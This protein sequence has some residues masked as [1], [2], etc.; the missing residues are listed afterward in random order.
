MKKLT[1]LLLTALLTTTSLFSQDFLPKDFRNYKARTKL[2]ER[3]LEINDT[4]G[5]II[6]PYD[7]RRNLWEDVWE[8]H[9]V[10]N[11]HKDSLVSEFPDAYSFDLNWDR[12]LSEE[13]MFFDLNRNGLLDYKEFYTTPGIIITGRKEIEL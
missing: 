3:Y 9:S 6:R 5:A 11:P 7:S 4:L 2:S 8:I 1:N 10:I 13:E 12:Y